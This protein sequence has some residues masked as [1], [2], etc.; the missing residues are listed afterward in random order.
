MQDQTLFFQYFSKYL[1]PQLPI[2]LPSIKQANILAASLC[3]RNRFFFADNSKCWATYD[4]LH[5]FTLYTIENDQLHMAQ[6]FTVGEVSLSKKGNSIKFWNSKLKQPKKIVPADTS[7]KQLWT[8]LNSPHIPDFPEFLGKIEQPIP[9]SVLTEMYNRLISD[10]MV[11][12]I[13]LCHFSVVK[14]RDSNPFQK[15]LFHV[16]S[17]AGKVHQY[18]NCLAMAEFSEE[19]LTPHTVLR[20]NS[21]LTSLFKVFSEEFGKK[22]YQD[23]IKDLLLEIDAKG[24]LKLSHPDDLTDSEKSELIDWLESILLRIVDSLRIVPPEMRHMAS[25]LKFYS[26]VRFNLRGATYNTLSGYFFLRYYGSILSSPSDYDHE[27]KFRSDLKKVFIPFA[28]LCQQVFNLTPFNGRF[29]CLASFHELFDSRIY[30]KLWNFLFDLSEISEVPFYK[31]PESFD[32][33]LDSLRSIFG[34]LK[35]NA[36]VFVERYRQFK[37]ETNS[38]SVGWAISGYLSDQFIPQSD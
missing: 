16:F 19:T 20:T 11:L 38:Q 8:L 12:V 5:C 9:E 6:S 24:D 30:S 37:Q 36:S 3:T 21:H 14:I 34:Y 31:K 7:Q 25:I 22:Y 17:Y 1:I 23:F 13:A 10:D 26:S 35:E 4:E 29:D 15:A 18:V 2:S 33:V 28:Q 32:S 27:T